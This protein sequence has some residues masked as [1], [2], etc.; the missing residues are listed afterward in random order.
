MP[1]STDT[2]KKRLNREERAIQ[3]AKDCGLT[4]L[5]VISEPDGTIRIVTSCPQTISSKL[6]SDADRAVIEFANVG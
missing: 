2:R 3:A 6:L 4:V 5:E 1:P